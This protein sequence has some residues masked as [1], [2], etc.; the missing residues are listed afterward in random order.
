MHPKIL[1][2]AVLLS[3][4]YV[5][6]NM[7]QTVSIG[8]S[9]GPAITDLNFDNDFTNSVFDP[10]LNFLAGANITLRFTEHFGIRSGFNFE[11][12][13]A[14]ADFTFT[15]VIG[16]PTSEGTHYERFD[17]FTVPFVLEASFGG[18]FR[19]IVQAGQSVGFLIQHT[20]RFTNH[21]PVFGNDKSHRTEDFKRIEYSIIGGLGF[22]TKISEAAAFQF[23]VRPSY[24][25]TN[26][27][28]DSFQFQGLDIRTFA[29]GGTLGLQLFLN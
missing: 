18:R 8:F 4:G 10:A 20:T 7:G 3:L 24:G 1:S 2:L 12:K 29:I 15:D 13:G 9:G 17:Y 5:S 19:G 21:D 26:I 11:R 27:N 14:K 25:V 6:K 23:L 16:G 28:N 22:E